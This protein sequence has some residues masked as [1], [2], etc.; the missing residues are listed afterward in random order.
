LPLA[1]GEALGPDEADV[2][3]EGDGEA[4]ELDILLKLMVI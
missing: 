3:A 4:D 2:V 1:S